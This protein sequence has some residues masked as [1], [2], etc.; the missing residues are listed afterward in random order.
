MKKII[1]ASFL[2]LQLS[3]SKSDENSGNINPSTD[4][5]IDL[6][7]WLNGTYR[8]AHY[9]T[10]TSF[11]VY[12]PNS[13]PFS[14]EFKTQNNLLIKAKSTTIVIESLQEKIDNFISSGKLISVEEFYNTVPNFT[15]YILTIRTK[16][17]P[18]EPGEDRIVFKI[19]KSPYMDIN[20]IKIDYEKHTDGGMYGNSSFYTLQ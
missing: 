17:I 4:T 5:K 7:D 19:T 15:S 3:C 10:T 20:Q 11:T 13:N 18:Q 1:L 16:P 6:P 12:Y 8:A 2:F 9:G 14:I